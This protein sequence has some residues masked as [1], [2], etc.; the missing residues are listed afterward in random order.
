MDAIEICRQ[1]IEDK[2]CY[3]VRP[4]KDILAEYDAKPY[5]SGN[6]RGWTYVDL[7]SAS[8]VLNVYRALNPENQSKFA[9]LPIE[10]MC[11]VAFK[12][13]K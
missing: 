5:G 8:A 3:V 1:I 9:A 6:K 2:Q 7:F 11:R 4:K 12:L 10:K 13:C